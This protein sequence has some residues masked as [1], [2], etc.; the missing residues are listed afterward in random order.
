MPE[1]DQEHRENDRERVDRR[2]EHERQ[3]RVQTTSAP[4]ADRP[5]SPI[6]TYTIRRRTP[7]PARRGSDSLTRRP[8]LHS[9]RRASASA[10]TADRDVDRHGDVRRDRHVVNA[11]QVES[12]EQ[13]AEHRAGD[14][15]A[16][17]EPEPGNAARRRL[18]PARDGGQRRAHQ[19]ASAAAGRSPH[20]TA[21]RRH[22]PRSR[23][24]RRRRRRASTSGIAEQHEQ[25]RATPMPSSSSA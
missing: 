7:A 6:A 25:A 8:A 22:A 16:V 21:R 19:A 17:E 11:Q 5:D 9:R 24:R 12:G 10:S 14:V 18:D 15:A 1:S 13:A 2:A 23:A 20:T 4:R 3:Q